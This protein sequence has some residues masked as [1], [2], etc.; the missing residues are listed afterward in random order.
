MNDSLLAALTFV[1][2]HYEQPCSAESLIAGL[3]LKNGQLTPHLFSRAAS[4]AGL[5]AIE[6]DLPIS[7][8]SPL[9]LPAVALLENNQACVVLDINPVEQQAQIAIG[10]PATST[11]GRTDKYITQWLSFSDLEQQFLNKVFLLKK[12]FK[13]DERSPEF[14]SSS[15]KHWFWSTI[16]QSKSIYRDVFIASVLINLFAI[17][18]PLF[19]RLVYDK[20][21]PNQAFDSLWVLVSGMAIIVGFDL[22]L[23]ILR[24]YFIDIAG[25]KSDLMISSAIYAKAVGMKMSSRPPSIGAF[26][27]HLQEFESIREFFTSTTI[28]SLI[29]LPFAFF[30]LLIIW[31]IAGPLVIVPLVAVCILILYCW[32]IQRPLQTSVEEGSKLVSQKHANLIESLTGL[33]TLK[34]FN[35]QGQFQFKW[36]QAVA[37]IANWGIKSRRLTDSVNNIANSTQQSVSV[38]VIV[39]GVYLIAAGDLSVGGLIATSMLTSRAIAPMVQLSQLSTR[40]HQAKSA[41]SIIDQIMS[42]PNEIDNQKHYLN[43]S[44][45]SGV[46]STENL[47]FSYPN[48]EPNGAGER[49]A[50]NNIT[51]SIQTGEKV[52]VIGKIG[53]GKSTLMRLITGLYSPTEGA[54]R[55]DNNDI[56]QLNPADIR[57]QIGCVP[58]D[59]T[60]FFGTIRENI[61]LGNS[62]ATTQDIHQACKLSGVSL[63]TQHE[64]EGIERQVGES[65]QRLSGG[66]KQAIAM[67]RALLQQPK[68]LI[69]DEPT[70]NMDNQSEQHIKRYLASLDKHHTVVL[71]SHKSSMLDVVDRLIVL[72]N[73][74]LVADGTKESVIKQLKT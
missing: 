72:D 69:L 68:I 62:Q 52:A 11:V 65:G 14:L 8:L 31:L 7:Q 33:E 57:R 1:C 49:K 9:L 50:L 48:T 28:A 18:L 5:S 10:I 19:T 44:A 3:P 60:L 27:R 30:F 71:F 54:I 4:N 2:R 59:I 36:E 32:L 23:K 40:Y 46:I 55:L 34:L 53:S 15:Q 26:A 20:I 51:F 42:T 47:G 25:R 38:A 74:K 43:T 61:T 13:Y 64:P 58:Q 12:H 21:V 39:V 56:H 37:H 45:L 66:Q 24:S 16:W 35:A 70:S 17:A 73:G 6:E 41:M 63:F 22:L 29:D 67:A